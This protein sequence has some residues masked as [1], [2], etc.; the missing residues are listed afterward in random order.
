MKLTGSHVLALSRASSSYIL[1]R[2]IAIRDAYSAA[3]LALLLFTFSST[4]A[5]AVELYVDASVAESGDGRTWDTAFRTIQE[6]IDAS[7]DGDT[8][9]VA[10]GTYLENIHFEGKNIGLR[11]RDSH[12]PSVVEETILDGNQSGPAVAFSGDE[13]ES[14]ILS[15]FAIRNGKGERGGGISGGTWTQ[16]TRAT[17]EHNVIVN[18][19]AEYDGGG[20]AYCDGFVRFNLITENS[21]DEG[22]GLFRCDAV[23]ERNTISSNS[24]ER[25]GGGL[26]DCDGIIRDNTIT[27][28]SAEL[29]GGLADCNGVIEGNYITDNNAFWDGQNSAYGGGLARCQ[30]VIQGNTISHNHAGVGGGLYLCDR[31]IRDNVIIQNDV[32]AGDGGGLADCDGLVQNNIIAENSAFY[33]GGL[34]D[35]DGTVDKNRITSNWSGGLY[36][37]DGTVQNNIILENAWSRHGAGGLDRCDGTIQNNVIAGNSPGLQFC[38]GEIRNNTIVGNRLWYGPGGLLGCTGTIMNCII[39]RNQGPAGTQIED[40]S[41]PTYSCIQDWSGGEGNISEDPGVVDPDGPDNDPETY[42]DNDYR[43]RLDSPCIDAAFNSPDLPEFDIAGMRRVMFGGKSLTVDMG[44][45]EYYINTIELG[46]A[47]H[48]A[49]LKWSS[50]AE[51]SYSVFYSDDLL[52]WHLAATNLPS[53]GNATTAWTDD[54]SLTGGVPPSLAP[55]RFYRILENQ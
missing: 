43:L 41:E 10:P 34:F 40:S 20:L 51:A 18:N 11:S 52:A 28:N 26:A 30:A 50:R 32:G 39:W 15:G 3:F 2:W 35:C 4:P 49:T 55:R 33:G 38:H 19:S 21:A 14:C 36:E 42:E 29:G 54:G 44:A 9:T 45:Y 31:I 8:V 16:H 22:G 23:I 48:H 53:A 25:S 7:S 37:C 6:G 5:P 13:N 47:A 46:P 12:D 27:N 1:H 24:A 17:I